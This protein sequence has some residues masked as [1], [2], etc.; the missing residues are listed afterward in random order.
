MRKELQE[1]GLPLISVVQGLSSH[2]RFA[3]SGRYFFATSSVA[4]WRM[5]AKLAPTMTFVQVELHDLVARA[6]PK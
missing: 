3:V 1:M 5:S 2:S 6:T 4:R